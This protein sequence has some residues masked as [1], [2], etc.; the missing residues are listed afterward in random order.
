MKPLVI[1]LYTDAKGSGFTSYFEDATST[2]WPETKGA[3]GAGDTIAEALRSLANAMDA[4]QEERQ[5]DQ[6]NDE[7]ST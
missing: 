2:E 1:I 7:A 6:F 5:L 3:V 4:L